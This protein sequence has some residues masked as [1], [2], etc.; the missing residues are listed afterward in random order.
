MVDILTKLSNKYRCDKSDKNHRYTPLYNK[1]FEE[2][3]D[4]E[5]NFIEFGYGIGSSVKMW[6]EY[7]TKAKLISIDFGPISIEKQIVKYIKSGRL[8]YVQA[9]QIDREYIKSNV[10]DKYKEFLFMID[11]ASHVAEDQQFTFN[12]CFPYVSNNGWYI[13]EDLKCKRGHNK[14][15]SIKA[16]KTLEVLENYKRTNKFESNILTEEEDVKLTKNIK[17]ITT[18]DKISFIRKV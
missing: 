8:E 14:K 1:L 12:F 17:E 10:L 13:I 15:F 11:D 2:I 7:F 5:F 16:D 3:R 18:I 4:K 9:N 6:L